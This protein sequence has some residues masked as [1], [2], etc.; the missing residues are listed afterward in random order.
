[1]AG[2]GYKREYVSR[3]YG[4]DWPEKVRKMPDYQVAMIYQRML[5]EMHELKKKPKRFRLRKTEVRGGQQL[6]LFEGKK[7]M[8]IKEVYLK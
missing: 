8:K 7:S 1:M 5:N 2:I 4:G 6:C 3:Q